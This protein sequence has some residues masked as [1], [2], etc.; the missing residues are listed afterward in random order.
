V[1][2]ED[3]DHLRAEIDRVFAARDALATGSRA[4]DG[5]YEEFNPDP[6]SYDLQSSKSRTAVKQGVQ[7]AVGRWNHSDSGIWAA[8]SPRLM[9]DML[10]LFEGA[11]LRRIA[12]GYLGEPPAISMQKCT[13]RKQVPAKAQVA[14]GW[15]QDGAFLGDVRALNVWLTLSHCGDEAPGLYLVPRRLER[16]VPTGT[17][18]AIFDWAVSPMTAE[19]AAAGLPILKP[20]FEPGDVM[21]F[22]ELY[23]HATASDPAMSKPRYAVESWFFGPSAFPDDVYGQGRTYV[24]L[25]A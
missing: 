3:A 4:E 8:D 12:R 18:G 16:I 1:G 14:P 7:P 2:S 24:P 10:E 6:E 9:F 23:L 11:G 13:L 5:Y 21:L 19:W 15:H 25:A 22:D 20:I 17:K